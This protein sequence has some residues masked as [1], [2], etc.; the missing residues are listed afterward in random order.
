MD[1]YEET[2]KKARERLVSEQNDGESEP[3]D[4]V[5]PAG[6]AEEENHQGEKEQF[7]EVVDGNQ[8]VDTPEDWERAFLEAY[9][10]EYGVEGKAAKAAGVHPIRVRKRMQES[11]GFKDLYETAQRMV[12]D[13]WHYEAARRALEPSERPI[14][15]RGKLVGVVKEYD[16]KHLQ[17]YLERR[18]PETYHIPTRVEFAG[19]HEG[20]INFKLE[21][22]PSSA[23]KDEDEE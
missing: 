12:D 4:P 23:E 5:R 10:N 15:Q 1:E 17:W 3:A 2:L 18:F 22:G 14:F 20:A 9:I 8:L 6:Q 13:I 19:E 7:P 16:N 11:P 21:L